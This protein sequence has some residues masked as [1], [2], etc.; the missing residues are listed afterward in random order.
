[1]ANLISGQ[2]DFLAQKRVVFGKGL[3][4]L[5]FAELVLE[6]EQVF[7]VEIPILE[8]EHLQTIQE[9]VLYING[10]LLDS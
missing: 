7:S 2:Y 4:S 3:D 1:M 8:A 6:L 9:A 5:D 10:K